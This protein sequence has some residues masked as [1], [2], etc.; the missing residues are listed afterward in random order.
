M[1]LLQL[2][3]TGVVALTLTGSAVAQTFFEEGITLQGKLIDLG[4]AGRVYNWAAL[5]A[6]G[7]FSAST[8]AITSPAK[9]DIEGNVG[10]WGG[11]DVTLNNSSILAD[12]YL[13]KGGS[14]MLSGAAEILGNF[15]QDKGKSTTYDNI[16]SHAATD[17]FTL[18]NNIS[19]LT[20]TTNFTSNFSLSSGD[21]LG[22]NTS[23]TITATNSNPVVLKLTDFVLSNASLTLIGSATSKFVI[24]ISDDFA[25]SNGSLVTFDGQLN[26][27]NV[28]FNIRDTAT[29]SGASEFNGIL[30]A[31]NKTVSLSGGS[32][33]FG[34]VIGKAI[35]MSAGS[36]IKKPKPPNLP[37]NL[38]FTFRRTGGGNE[39]P[40]GAA[41]PPE[42]SK[43][44]FR[45]S[46][47]GRIVVASQSRGK[48][49]NAT[50]QFDT[51]NTSSRRTPDA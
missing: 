28:I 29:M 42:S 51:I 38:E 24:D 12:L 23:L 19:A 7:K 33:V 50:I 21:I 48:S 49:A 18:A 47:L 4:Y 34:E 46:L 27:K 9:I 11:S 41:E 45:G 26:P 15:Y 36:K 8:N 16:L 2:F 43:I 13:R 32:S 37:R 10:V 5:T 35:T 40:L 44:G 30:L 14:K 39:L 20:A 31:A 3:T 1:K 6:N 25:M 17:A 22:F